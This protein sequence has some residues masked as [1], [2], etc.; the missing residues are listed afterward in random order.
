MASTLGLM[1]VRT[2]YHRAWKLPIDNDQ[3]Q[4]HSVRC[5]CCVCD[6][7]FISPCHTSVRNGVD[8][9]WVAIVRGSVAP[10]VV[11]TTLM[12]SVEVWD[13]CRG[14]EEAEVACAWE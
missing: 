4:L 12:R 1:D 13:E 8:V 3:R 6:R 14:V 2:F 7:P 5:Q 10:G 11:G 9:V